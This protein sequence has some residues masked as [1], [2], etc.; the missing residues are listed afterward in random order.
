MSRT[1][2]RAELEAKRDKDLK[3]MCSQG[4]LGI[5]GMW[6]KNKA[7]VINAILAKQSETAG[8]ATISKSAP[9]EPLKGIDFKGHSVM[10]KPGNKFGEKTSTTI[11]VSCGASS[12]AFPVEGRTVKEVGEFLREVLN[13]DKLSTGLVNGK[14]VSADYKLKAGDALEFLKPAG[15]KG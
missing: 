14:E 11:Q 1:Y 9:K 15:K 4:Q 6:K 3:R 7:E 13:V 5:P 2:T 8:S 10:T 12:G